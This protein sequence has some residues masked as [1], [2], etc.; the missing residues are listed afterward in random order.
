M[1]LRAITI[2]RNEM[3]ILPLFLGHCD[4]LFDE[5]FLIDHQSID[6]S[7]EIIKKAIT[8]RKGWK[9]FKVSFKP[10]LQ[11][12]IYNFFIDRFSKDDVD[13]LFLLDPDEFVLSKDRMRLESTLEEG[14]KGHDG[15]LNCRWINAAIDTN[16]F[17]EKL[18]G[19][20]ELLVS[21]KIS[22]FQKVIIPGNLIRNKPINISLGQHVAYDP[23]GTIYNSKTIG[24]YLHV[25]IRSRTQL[26]RKAVTNEI[27]RLLDKERVSGESYQFRVFLKL[28]QNNNLSV[29]SLIS[30][31]Y[32]YEETNKIIPKDWVEYFLKK[33]S[34]HA[35]FEDLDLA[36]NSDL[37]LPNNYSLL[38]LEL[39]IADLL[40]ENKQIK[41]S[42]TTITLK[43]NT[44]FLAPYN[45]YPSISEFENIEFFEKEQFKSKDEINGKDK[46]LEEKDQ[47]IKSLISE[48]IM[49]ASSKSWRVTRPLRK[50]LKYFR[51]K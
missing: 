25:P 36:F 10:F 9:Y 44:L 47:I 13:F 1:K 7:S 24:N 2:F 8:Q 39:L 48:N 40:L 42:S 22:P 32:L 49:Y 33:G 31:L 51:K 41:P 11:K 3:D 21:K 50:V 15:V 6:N 26:I 18:S 12:E 20:T 16:H 35:T 17:D 19:K 37:K 23:F 4:A 34:Y 30:A 28:L 14:I 45:K 38:P 43:G 27:A 29:E 5:V 46:I